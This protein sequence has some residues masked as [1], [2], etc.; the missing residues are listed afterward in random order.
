MRRGQHLIDL[1]R[2]DVSG[3]DAADAAPVVVDLQHDLRRGLE[4]L[5]EI[6]LQHHDDELHRRVVVVEQD[7]LVHLRRRCLLRPAL[8]NDRVAVVRPG[9]ATG[10]VSEVEGILVP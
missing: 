3:V 10:G 1:G 4:V 5:V 8:E 6:L 9:L 7:H 2:G